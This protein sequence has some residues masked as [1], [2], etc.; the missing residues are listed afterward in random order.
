M[1]PGIHTQAYTYHGTGDTPR[2]A[3]LLGI[4]PLHPPRE[5]TLLGIYPYTHPGRLPCWVCTPLLYTM[6]GMP[7]TYTTV[8]HHGRHAWYTPGYTTGCVCPPVYLSGV[9]AHRCTSQGVYL[10]LGVPQGV[11]LL[12]G[13]P[14][15]GLYRGFPLGCVIPGIPSRVDYSRYSRVGRGLI[16]VIPGLGEVL[17]L[18]Y[19]GFSLP[20]YPFYAPFMPVLCSFL[21]PFDQECGPEGARTGGLAARYSLGC[22]RG[23]LGG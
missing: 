13:V 1:V 18:F 9:Y 20:F 8:I 21:L 19:V 11:Y 7:G 14:Q 2:E 16:T 10:L 5:D 4:Y 6:G 17:S 15:G 3:T 12:L 22:P 23:L